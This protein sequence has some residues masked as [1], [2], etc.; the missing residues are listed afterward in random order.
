[1]S[2]AQLILGKQLEELYSRELADGD[3][4]IMTETLEMLIAVFHDRMQSLL[5]GWRAQKLNVELHITCFAGGIYNGWYTAVSIEEALGERVISTD[6]YT[7]LSSERRNETYI[8]KKS[9][10]PSGSNGRFV[11]GRHIIYD[12][13]SSERLPLADG[14]PLIIWIR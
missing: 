5:R 7:V 4:E 6:F 11:A 14:M 8:G 10:Q 13:Y 3:W 12:S 2:I 9:D 1:L